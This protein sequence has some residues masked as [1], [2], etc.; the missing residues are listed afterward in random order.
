[1]KKEDLIR[2]VP[3]GAGEELEGREFQNLAVNIGIDPNTNAK[4]VIVALFDGDDGDDIDEDSNFFAIE[5][6]LQCE[7]VIDCLK[8]AMEETFQHD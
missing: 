8:K 1:M 5:T 6:R 2:R 7:A 3:V 4:F